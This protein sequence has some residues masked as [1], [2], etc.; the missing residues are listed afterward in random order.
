METVAGMTGG[1][2]Y[3]VMS[4]PDKFF[5]KV[6]IA[7][8]G[9][10]RLGIEEPANSPKGKDFTVSARVVKTG[11]TVKANRTAVPPAA[12]GPATVMPV[13]DQLLSAISVGASRY[14][15]PISL[16]TALR[17]T[18]NT[19][20]VDLGV[21]ITI[22]ATVQGPLTAVFALVDDAGGTKSGRKVVDAPADPSAFRLAFN[23]PVAPGIYRLR[24]AVADAAGNIGSLESVVSA[25]LMTMGPFTASDL[26]TSWIGKDDK[27]QFLALEEVPAG[28]STLNTTLELYPPADAPVPDNVLVTL[29]LEA[30]GQ[31]KPLFEKEIDP[32]SGTG[33]LRADAAF[34]FDTLAPGAYIIRAK[35]SIAGK[36]VGAT[37][38]TVR[39][40]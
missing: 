9:I 31:S 27:P 4:T 34:P 15:V 24:F 11:L 2:V 40:K 32:D 7:A 3:R 13:E 25:K 5:D 19:T 37:A 14:S 20:Q 16:A 39:K 8:S 10:Y 22:P 38:A 12:E 29:S 30:Q 18:P 35:V 23:L 17:H 21:N 28:V 26:L 36:E 6:A 1:T 33:L